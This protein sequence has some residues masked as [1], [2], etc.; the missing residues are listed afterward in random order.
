[1]LAPGSG[2]PSERVFTPELIANVVPDAQVLVHIE[3]RS[4]VICPIRVVAPDAEAKIDSS[5]ARKSAAAGCG[6][7]R[8][9]EREGDVSEAAAARLWGS[10]GCPFTL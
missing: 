10:A 6:Q 7:R 2:M 5:G 4:G 3:A 8:F 9:P 1:M